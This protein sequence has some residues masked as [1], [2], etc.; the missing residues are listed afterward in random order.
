MFVL[1][2]DPIVSFFVLYIFFSSLNL[3]FSYFLLVYVLKFVDFLCEIFLPLMLIICVVIM[4]LIFWDKINVV[5]SNSVTGETFSVSRKWPLYSPINKHYIPEQDT[6][7]EFYLHYE[8]YV[9]SVLST[10]HFYVTPEPYKHNLCSY[11][12]TTS[13]IK[14]IIIK[15]TT[16]FLI[17]FMSV[18]KF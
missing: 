5:L 9:L 10:T 4:V 3:L 14:K 11:S 1:S 17:K 6:I 16:E 7:I 13:S 15:G 2:R 8:L 12:N 18:H